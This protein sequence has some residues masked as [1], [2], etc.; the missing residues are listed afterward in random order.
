MAPIALILLFLTGVG[1]LLAWRKSTLNILMNQFM[2]PAIAFVGT[3]AALAA[4]GIRVWAS[5]ICFSLCALVAATI[6]QEFFRG[7]NVRR[8]NTGT[9]IFTAL[10]GLVGRN[11]RRYGGY[12]VHIGIV[13]MFLGFAGNGYKQETEVLLKPGQQHTLGHFT[14][15]NDGVKVS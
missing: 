4:L 6:A 1:P 3:A 15:R 9:D 14:L 13:L 8:R 5:G 10:V 11:K 2:W 12:I 7:A